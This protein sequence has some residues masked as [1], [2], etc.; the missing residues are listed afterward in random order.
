MIQG[1][2]RIKHPD[3]L[4]ALAQKHNFLLFE[5]RKFVEFADTVQHQLYN[6][7]FKMLDWA[8]FI[9]CTML[10]GVGCVAGLAQIIQSKKHNQDNQDTV[11][12]IIV[13][14]MAASGS[15]ANSGYTEGCVK[16][17][18]SFPESVL[19]FIA[20]NKPTEDYETDF[21]TF[22]TDIDL[23]R[24]KDGPVLKCQTPEEAIQRGADVIFVGKP[25]L[26]IQPNESGLMPDA[27]KAV[28]IQYQTLG[29]L[30]YEK[31]LVE[32]SS[33]YVQEPGQSVE[34]SNENVHPEIGDMEGILDEEALFQDERLFE[35]IDFGTSDIEMSGEE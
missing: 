33:P 7:P 21:L 30:A 26:E 16:V 1:W 34:Q 15:M 24:Q 22:A 32:Q 3:G 11:G 12:L 8:D 29:W 35:H 14:E 4:C 25:L 2:S 13:A 27:M 18:K 31:L 6:S 10:A 28:A 19:G 9:S 17:A 23:R 5:D 20:V